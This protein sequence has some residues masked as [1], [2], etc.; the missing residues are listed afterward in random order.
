MGGLGGA[1]V[2]AAKAARGAVRGGEAACRHD[3]KGDEE[4]AEATGE[5]PE[6]MSSAFGYPV[7]LS[8]ELPYTRVVWYD[9][10]LDR[11]GVAWSAA[12]ER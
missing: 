4:V 2:G 11:G 1:A 8:S 9:V 7:D 3:A 6:A 10:T 5:S 12:S